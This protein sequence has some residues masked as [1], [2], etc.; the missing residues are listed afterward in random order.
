MVIGSNYYKGST[1]TRST[2]Y[3]HHTSAFI[4][5][6]LSISLSLTGL[7][8]PKVYSYLGGEVTIPEHRIWGH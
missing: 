6:L 8:G 5:I 1:P 4:K 7:H 2:F 3:S